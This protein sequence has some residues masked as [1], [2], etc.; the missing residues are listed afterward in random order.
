MIC[1]TSLNDKGE[2]I[3][4]NV[5]ECLHFSLKKGFPVVYIN[6]KRIVLKNHMQYLCTGVYPRRNKWFIM[7]ETQ[8]RMKMEMENPHCLDREILQFYFEF[9]YLF[10]KL[11]LKDSA[12]KKRIIKYMDLIKIN[13]K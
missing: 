7:D 8:K 13:E 9:I 1:N 5:C 11:S 3:I 2:P 10:K 12:A 4:N 6:G